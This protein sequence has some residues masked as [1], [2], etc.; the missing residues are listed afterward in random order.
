MK[1]EPIIKPL[2]LLFQGS[3]TIE[4]AEDAEIVYDEL[5]ALVQSYGRDCTLNGQVMKSLE[6]CCKDRKDKKN[7]DENPKIS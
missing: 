7:V 3:I 5:K 1:N 6:P 4:N 2:R